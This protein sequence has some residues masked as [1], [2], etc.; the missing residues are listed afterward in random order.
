MDSLTKDLRCIR[1]PN[2]SPL[3]G[4]GTNTFLLGH[5]AV[6]VIDPGPDDPAHLDA[7]VRAGDGRISHILVTHAHLDH[8]AGARRL[9][10]MTGAPM[11]AFGGATAGRSPLMRR[12]AAEGITGGGEGLDHGF[13]PDVTLRD[14]DRV[15]GADWVL[16]VLHTPG[17]SG[18]HLAFGWG[19]RILC[20]DVVM[21]WSS[22]IISPPDGDL[23]DYLRTL[24]RLAEARARQLLPAHGAPIDDPAAR[25]ADLAAHRRERTVQILAALSQGPANAETLARRIYDIAPPLLPAATR[26]VLA[27]LLALADLGAVVPRGE[28]H[29]RAEFSRS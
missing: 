27:H 26:N 11:L 15:E 16:S 23:S 6:A 4:P 10:Q 8:S 14:G 3:T 7:I 17:H 2:A 21:G 28:L 12:L 5:E 18:G 20:G 29:P 22:T 13:A 19:D 1:A 24:D 9:A 25:L